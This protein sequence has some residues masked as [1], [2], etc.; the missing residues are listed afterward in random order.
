ML[1]IIKVMILGLVEGITEW[2]PISSTG[3]LIL[4]DEFI[5]LNASDAFKEMFNVVVQLGAIMAVVV[6]YFNKLNPFSQKKSRKQRIHTIQLWMKVIVACLPAAVLGILFDDWM[7]EHFHNYIVVAIMLIVYGVLFIWVEN[8]NKKTEPSVTKL[9]TLS[10]KTALF[11]GLFQVLS[12]IPGTSRS[13]ATILGA[14][15]LGVSRY[16]AAE[17]TFFLA[18][19][20]MFGASGIKL[21]KFFGEGAGITGME[22]AMLSVGCI[23]AF[24]VS[25]IAIKFLMGYIKKNDFKVFG[26][27][28]IILG[29]LVLGYFVIAGIAA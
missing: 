12:L 7:E 8:W 21:L 14:L 22:V 23:V 18:I 9:S 27:Y 10:Y 4:V 11:I 29:I 26:Y 1:E 13:G 16:V 25:V 24:V 17:F 20:V 5:K 2:L 15:L 28:R 3:H 19:P 6:L